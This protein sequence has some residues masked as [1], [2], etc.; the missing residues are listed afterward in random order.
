M[1]GRVLQAGFLDW[2]AGRDLWR[3][4]CATASCVCA[5]ASGHHHRPSRGRID[6]PYRQGTP[7]PACTSLGGM[8]RNVCSGPLCWKRRKHVYCD[9]SK[10]ARARLSVCA[11]SSNIWTLTPSH[12]AIAQSTRVCREPRVT[13]WKAFVKPTL[14]RKACLPLPTSVCTRA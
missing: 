10:A 5:A 2:W 11:C 14:F 12:I 9:T 8:D 13:I 7:G 6:H 1:L 4:P 3:G